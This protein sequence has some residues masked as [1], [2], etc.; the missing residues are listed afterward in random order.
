MN[1]SP[2]ARSLDDTAPP[3]RPSVATGQRSGNTTDTHRPGREHDWRLAPAAVFTWA[4]CWAAVA[5][6]AS[7]TWLVVFCVLA[8]AA[9]VLRRL[10]RRYPQASRCRSP[11]RRRWHD[12]ARLRQSV[13]AGALLGLLIAAVAWSSTA[14]QVERR[15]AWVS[16]LDGETAQVWLRLTKEPVPLDGRPGVRIDTRL[17]QV[18]GEVLDLPVLVLADERWRDLPVGAQVRVPARLAAT[19]PGDSRAL[20]VFPSGAGERE[21]PQGWRHLVAQLRGG[22]VQASASLP[23]AARGLVPGIAL[24]DDR[25]LP[26]Q[27]QQAMQDTSLTHL[28][29]VSGAH[30]A[31]VLALVLL[32]LFWA[33]RVVRAGAGALVLVA[34]VALVRPDGSVLRSAVMG[35]V[36]LVG[37]CLRRPRAAMPALCTAVIVLLAVDPWMA[38]SFGFALSVLA[39]GG[40]LAGT[41]VLAGRL[42][43]WLPRPVAW[44]V[45][46]PAAAQVAC[47]PVLLLLDPAVPMYAVPANLLAGP[48]VAPA[49]IL[50]LLAAGLAPVAPAPAATIAR[51][52]SWFTAWISSVALT[53]AEFPAAR[54]ETSGFTV[55]AVALLIV[56]MLVWRSSRHR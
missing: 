44:A 3:S 30:V 11:D 39:T 27:L 23:P 48:A 49:T 22:L 35:G 9:I 41:G 32:A 8:V 7:L 47:T 5:L 17:L 16:A 36:L 2:A 18:N 28:T 55:A 50:G 51:A 45:A 20:L 6:P 34:F 19:E 15:T 54:V 29:A 10:L 13:L 46:V 31:L 40:L 24:G 37:L 56:T 42:E 1:E 12:R 26:P 4:G 14:V 53:F 33:P 21:P 43:R 38:R 52:A 25:A